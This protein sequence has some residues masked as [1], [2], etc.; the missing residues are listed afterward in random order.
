VTSDDA[1]VIALM[2]PMRLLVDFKVFLSSM[3]L[4]QGFSTSG[5]GYSSCVVTLKIPSLAF[6]FETSNVFISGS[7]VF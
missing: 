7:S 3:G 1:V 6:I 2:L 5:C 4:N